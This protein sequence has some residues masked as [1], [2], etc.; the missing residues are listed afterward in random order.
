MRNG[1]VLIRYQNLEAQVLQV[2]ISRLVGNLRGVVHIDVGPA[3]DGG[4]RADLVAVPVPVVPGG[5]QVVPF[6]GQV[7]VVFLPIQ[8]V[9]QVITEFSGAPPDNLSVF[10]VTVEDAV[11]YDLLQVIDHGG[12][13]GP[14][15]HG[16]LA[17]G[18][19]PVAD[20]VA[21]D[22]V[23]LIS[24]GAAGVQVVQAGQIAGLLQDV[25]KRGTLG[26]IAQ[27]LAHG[28]LADV[29]VAV[30]VHVDGVEVCR[31]GRVEGQIAFLLCITPDT[32]FG[33][34]RSQSV[35]VILSAIQAAICGTELPS[36]D[37]LITILGR[38][39]RTSSGGHRLLV[40]NR[41]LIVRPAET[42]LNH[43]P[44]I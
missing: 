4:I 37:G 33:Y 35:V 28:G 13:V 41:V 21:P 25:L 2:V 24:G 16:A 44:L 29:V 14:S 18:S 15:F 10:L 17:D 20:L 6:P 30:D 7:H 43:I 34:Q 39:G 9:Q 12:Q 3:V 31:I 36:N 26:V 23:P 27:V 38:R 8:I 22:F 19:R 5:I 42:D 11:D 32:F 1:A 40:N